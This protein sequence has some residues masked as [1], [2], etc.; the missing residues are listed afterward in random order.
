[1]TRLIAA[2]ALA[3]AVACQSSGENEPTPAK[4]STPAKPE[5]ATD[6]PEIVP[7][8]AD[9]DI[10]QFVANELAR[11]ETDGYRVIVY[12]GATWCAPCKQ[13]KS[14]VAAGSLRA[15][16]GDLRILEFDSD[17][18]DP[19][20]NAAGYG[21]MMIPLFVLPGSDGR[22]TDVR[23]AGAP[24]GPGAVDIIVPQLTELLAGQ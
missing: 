23:F 16:F 13:F 10:A 7:G 15:Q 9:G 6:G 14:A 11:G 20:L 5:R 22:G 12:V 3:L 17:R 1:M 19:R 4:A 8:N 18:D 24:K 2:A 21:S